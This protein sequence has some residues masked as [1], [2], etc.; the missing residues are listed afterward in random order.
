M[1]LAAYCLNVAPNASYLCFCAI[2]S[3]DDDAENDRPE[4]GVNHL[5]LCSGE[6]DLEPLPTKGKGIM[7][8]RV[9]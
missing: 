6:A 3:R 7:V 2:I 9:R 8:W 5:A 1:R 4:R